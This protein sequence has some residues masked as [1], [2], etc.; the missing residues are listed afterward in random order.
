MLFERRVLSDFFF[1]SF[2]EKVMVALRISLG[3]FRSLVQRYIGFIFKYLN[4]FQ[5]KVGHKMARP[6]IQTNQNLY[7]T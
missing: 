3:F 6:L 2:C 7:C 5:S 4:N 1:K